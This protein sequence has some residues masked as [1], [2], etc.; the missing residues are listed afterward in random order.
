MVRVERKLY[1]S[2]K[3]IFSDIEFEYESPE[4]IIGY[5]RERTKGFFLKQ[6]QYLLLNSP[7]GSIAAGLILMSTIDYLARYRWKLKYGNKK[8]IVKERIIEWITEYIPDLSE[9]EIIYD[10]YRCGLVHEGRI[11]EGNIFDP[12]NKTLITKI[13]ESLT[14]NPV[15]LLEEIQNGLKRFCEDIVSNGKIKMQFIDILKDDFNKDNSIGSYVSKA[16]L[17]SLKIRIKA[18]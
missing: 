8:P 6:A 16:D 7:F 10:T 17:E 12:E 13:G 9:P 18:P 3:R 5:F 14:I 1:F 11:K 15:R 2:P 4:V